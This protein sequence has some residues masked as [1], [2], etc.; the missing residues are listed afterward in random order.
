MGA[1]MSGV[2]SFG[3][4][5]GVTASYGAFITA[6]EHV[7]ARVHG[8]SQQ[9]W[10][11]LTGDP[12][13]T[14]IIINGHAGPKTGEDGPTHADPQPLQ[15]LQECFPRKVLITLTPWDANE[16]WPMMVTALQK[17]PAI[18]APFVSRPADT[19]LDREKLGIPPAKNPAI[20]TSAQYWLLWSGLSTGWYSRQFVS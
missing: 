11:W 15:L 14:W 1:F 6:M 8:I 16:M 12:Y 17:R 3:E 7:A 4:H 13:N 5:V 9:S 10:E 19:I 20:P 2:A 18:L